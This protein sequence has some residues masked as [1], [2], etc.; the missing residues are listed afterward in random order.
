M[1]DHPKPYPFLEAMDAYKAGRSLDANPHRR[2]STAWVRWREGWLYAER[3]YGDPIDQP[4]ADPPRH[5]LVRL[6]DR[7]TEPF[8][9]EGVPALRQPTCSGCKYWWAYTGQGEGTGNC[10]R[11]AP[12]PVFAAAGAEAKRDALWPRTQE[13]DGCGEFVTRQERQGF[14]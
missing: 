1:P 6:F 14:V 10:R 4:P 11:Y 5:V 9:G 8:R 12:R 3:L 13:A 2:R 7:L